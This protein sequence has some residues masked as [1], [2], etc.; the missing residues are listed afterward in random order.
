MKYIKILVSLTFI[1]VLGFDLQATKIIDNKLNA[2]RPDNMTDKN[3]HGL[4]Q[5]IFD[6]QIIPSEFDNIGISIS[7]DPQYNRAILGSTNASNNGSNSGAAYVFELENDHWVEKV[8]LLAADGVANQKFGSSVG[9]DN[10]WLV[11]G[12]PGSNS[13]IEGLVYLYYY[14]GNQWSFFDTLHSGDLNTANLFGGSVRINA[15]KIIV[16]DIL[17]RDSSNS[18]VT[19]AVYIFDYDSNNSQW[20]TPIK[21]LP[22]DI[23]IGKEF[24]EYIDI[25]ANATRLAISADG[26]SSFGTRSG[27]VYIFDLVGNNWLQSEKL[28]ATNS[29]LN[30]EFGQQLALSD[31]G[32]I[33]VARSNFNTAN[34]TVSVFEENGSWS[35]TASLTDA[36]SETSNYI[37]SLDVSNQIIAVGKF[38]PREVL[39]YKKE[40]SNWVLNQVINGSANIGLYDFDIQSDRMLVANI[41]I[42]AKYFENLPVVKTSKQGTCQIQSCQWSQQGSLE[43]TSSSFD[44]AFGIAIDVSENFAIVGS[45]QDDEKANNA[46]AAYIFELQNNNNWYQVK[47]LTAN[48]GQANAAFGRSVAIDATRALVGAFTDDHYNNDVNINIVNAGSVY[49]FDFDGLSWFQTDKITAEEGLSEAGDLFGLSIDLKANRC[50]IGAHS[51]DENGT[52]SGAAYVF[53]F[54][55]NHWIKTTKIMP[56]DANIEDAFGY[57]VSLDGNRALI[58]AYLNDEVANNT[59]AAYIYQYEPIL[60]SWQMQ[61]KLLPVVFGSAGD[62]FGT[63]VSLDGNNALIGAFFDDTPNTSDN[64]G[65]VYF[66]QKDMNSNNWNQQQVLNASDAQADDRFGFS[67]KLEGNRALIGSWLNDDNGLDSGSAYLF[68]LNTTTQQWLEKQKIIAADGDSED[69]FGVS[70]GLSN[71]YLFI[72]AHQTDFIESDTGSVYIFIDDSIFEN[73]FD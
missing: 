59:G 66:F 44:D 71:N 11:I 55:G 60:Q 14:D 35:Q 17:A 19:G 5:A 32:S 6:K 27:A 46:G 56:T 36:N 28:I 43:S 51:D 54:D 61:D 58:G 42:G 57:S 24:G 15:D 22:N 47:K 64:K 69:Y 41:N 30:S 49:V 40:N 8:K 25:S 23:A 4:K 9:I 34:A 52:N 7:L 38:S 26:D 63:A 62:Y 33:V 73:G 2:I 31:D 1:L 20:S 53:D 45:H 16:G 3:W 70:V 68:K 13:T 65:S 37:H 12:A 72:G 50:L 21:I 67:V 10:N 18:I 39:I 48:D 29:T